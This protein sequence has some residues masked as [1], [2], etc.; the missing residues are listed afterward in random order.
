MGG[1]IVQDKPCSVRLNWTPCCKVF[2]VQT[3][4][5]KTRRFVFP[6]NVREERLNLIQ[7]LSGCQFTMAGKA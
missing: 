5:V 7:S 3:D 2:S 4:R 6:D 1:G